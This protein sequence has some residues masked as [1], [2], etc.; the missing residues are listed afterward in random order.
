MN[1]FA[2]CYLNTKRQFVEELLAEIKNEGYLTAGDVRGSLYSTLDALR[3]AEL[4][5]LALHE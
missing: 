3:L 1:K 5:E 2:E 4:Q